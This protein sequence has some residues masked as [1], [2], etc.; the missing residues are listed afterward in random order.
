MAASQFV[1]YSSKILFS[2]QK[3]SCL[4]FCYNFFRY[5]CIKNVLR[6]CYFFSAMAASAPLTIGN[7]TIK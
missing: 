6:Y 2:P 3:F 1:V 7:V 5:S 4:K